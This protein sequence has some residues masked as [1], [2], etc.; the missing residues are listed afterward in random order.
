MLYNK[1]DIKRIIPHREPMLLVDEI[2]EVNVLDDGNIIVKGKK[3][4]TG[5]ED[6]FKG[7][8]PNLPVVPGVLVLEAIAQTGAVYCLS[9]EENKGKNVFLVG[10]DNIK[11]RRS[12][13]PKEEVYITITQGHVRHGLGKAHGEAYVDGCLACQADLVVAIR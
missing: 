9:L 12:I 5:E 6:F 3:T 11:W 10:A 2:L 1:E 8:F 4:F 13:L 7:H